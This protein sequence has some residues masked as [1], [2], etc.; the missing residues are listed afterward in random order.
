LVIWLIVLVLEI[1]YE[2]AKGE[3]G[4]ALI[5]PQALVSASRRPTSLP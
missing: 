2:N 4:L 1:L 5:H 3:R